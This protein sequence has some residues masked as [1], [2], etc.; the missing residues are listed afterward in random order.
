MKSTTVLLTALIV[1]ILF[2]TQCSR[3][4]VVTIQGKV[5]SVGYISLAK[6]R[7]AIEYHSIEIQSEGNSYDCKFTPADAD[8]VLGKPL[9]EKLLVP[10]RDHETNQ[11]I[12]TDEPL[13]DK[14]IVVTLADLESVGQNRFIAKLV[15]LE[16]RE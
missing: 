4:K 3:R 14:V 8:S 10:D 6:D 16:V 12:L 15:K 7:N 13:H 1:C 11:L 5:S 9:A 2:S